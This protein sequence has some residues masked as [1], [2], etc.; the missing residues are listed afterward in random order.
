MIVAEV[1]QKLEASPRLVETTRAIWAV[2]GAN[3]T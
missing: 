2:V 3:V 1:R